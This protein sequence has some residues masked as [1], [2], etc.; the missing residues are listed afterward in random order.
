MIVLTGM[1]FL[2]KLLTQ[3]DLKQMST[4]N[5]TYV[6]NVHNLIDYVNEQ[7]WKHFIFWLELYR[8]IVLMIYNSVAD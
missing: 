3:A 4:C 2:S 6:V 1:T 8:W 5:L 7:T